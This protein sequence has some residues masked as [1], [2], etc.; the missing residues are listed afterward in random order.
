MAEKI[1]GIARFLLRYKIIVVI[2]LFVIVAGFLDPNSFLAR[3]RLTNRNNQLRAEIEE[4]DR[5]YA[6]AEKELQSLL[7]DPKAVERVA[8]VHLFMKSTDEDVYVVEEVATDS[9]TQ[10]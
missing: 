3:Y 2:V 8:R 4:C 7:S 6:Q 5:Q 10:E 1:G 9:T